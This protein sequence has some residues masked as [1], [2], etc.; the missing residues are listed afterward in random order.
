MPV[1][2]AAGVVVG[3]CTEDV[4]DRLDVDVAAPGIV[5]PLVDLVVYF[6]QAKTRR[7]GAGVF[8]LAQ[9][10][11]DPT[12]G[13]AY[14]GIRPPDGLDGEAVIYM[15]A[16]GGPATC[17]ADPVA[18]PECSCEAPR[19]YG[20]VETNVAG[21]TRLA[22]T[23]VAFNADCDL[24][25]DL[26]PDCN[27]TEAGCCTQFDG[28]LIARID[29]CA[30]TA[31]NPGC[32]GRGCDTRAA[33]PFRPPELAATEAVTE[34]ELARH[35]AWCGDGLDNDCIGGDVPCTLADGDGDGFPADA[36]CDDANTAINP[37]AGEICGNEIDENCDGVRPACD[38]DMDGVFADRDCDDADPSRFPGNPEICDDGIDQDCSGEDLLCL[39]DDLDG[40]GVDCPFDEP[41]ESH[42]CGA[43]GQDC[44]DLNAG[45]YPGAQEICG[46]GID[47][48]CDGAD[49]PCPADDAD[50]DGARDV[51]VGGTDCDD[52]DSMIFPGA[53]EKCG[54]GIDQDCDGVD[55]PCGQTPDEDGDGWP[56]ESDCND[57]SSDTFPGAPE[58][59]N[60]LDDDCDGL[61]DEGNP[62]ATG[63]GGEPAPV[64]CGSDCP[65]GVPCACRAAPVV[66]TSQGGRLMGE[67]RLRCLGRGPD[68]LAEACNGIDDDCDG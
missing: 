4:A 53:R 49:L 28:A 30:D 14:L 55:L 67:A 61:F 19:A 48:D 32:V 63:P 40:D 68:E 50:G 42:S 23:L 1:A 62:L 31:P 6:E 45:V 2:L 10:G 25:G 5:G 54:D 12:A 11:V 38:N 41:W 22:V 9:S 18:L 27:R 21:A 16:C 20:A 15:V 43:P 59:C 29:D 57:N 60:G 64:R 3:A 34:A 39:N 51:A 26:F 66:C 65:E 33:H 52:R 7:Y 24:D 46:D 8:H 44:N 37:G 56:V 35:S 13:P 58:W 36:D 47:Q 17:T